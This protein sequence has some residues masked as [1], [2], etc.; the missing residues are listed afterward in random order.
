MPVRFAN[1]ETLCL[2][3]STRTLI[4]A[5]LTL[6][7]GWATPGGAYRSESALNKLGRIDFSVGT[8]TPEMVLGGRDLVGHLASTHGDRYSGSISAERKQQHEAADI[9]D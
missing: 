6:Q 5:P 7:W 3:H 4:D 2:Q 8:E 9:Y 1:H